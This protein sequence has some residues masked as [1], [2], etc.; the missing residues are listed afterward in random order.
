M[1]TRLPLFLSATALSTIA[2]TP[3]FAE[4]GDGAAA[5]TSYKSAYLSVVADSKV[6]AIKN[7]NKNVAS[8][9]ADIAVDIVEVDNAEAVTL[10]TA[11]TSAN[12]TALLLD[13]STGT[14]IFDTPAKATANTVAADGSA[15]MVAAAAAAQ[16]SSQRSESFSVL[17]NQDSFFGFY[18]SFNGLIPIGDNIDFSFY[19]ILWTNSGFSSTA[20][21]PAGVASDNDLWTEFGAGV[22]IHTM[23]GNLVIKPQIGLT[24][25]ALLSSGFQED[26]IPTGTGGNFA[27][28]IVPSLTMNYSDDSFE[29]EF[30]GGYYAALR[31]RNDDFALDFL[32]TWIN[33]GAK[34]SD[35]FS[36][37]AHYE[38]LSNTRNTG[39]DTAVVYQWLGPYV[40]FSTS[41]GFFARFTAGADI[42]GGND[43]DF[44]K[45]TA[46][47][48]F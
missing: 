21:G 37:G 15:A 10:D 9:E 44:Y 12:S 34:I 35:N 31:N 45:L 7:S 8:D 1:K 30:Y 29:A 5:L 40:Q 43:G 4:A 19:G 25:G 39:G 16:G 2:A 18:P 27:D 23:D 20:F 24:N 6:N 28:G 46:G 32:H 36:A 47:F 3:A 48:S 38:L 41:N 13:G 42:E 14:D 22:A 11:L 33:A 17:L 26:G